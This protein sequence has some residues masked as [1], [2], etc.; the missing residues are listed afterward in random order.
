MLAAAGL[1]K[2]GPAKAGP[3]LSELLLK[4]LLFN[5][6]LLFVESLCAWV[7]RS[8]ESVKGALK[9]DFLALRMY[10]CDILEVIEH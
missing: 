7:E 4:E 9:C 2:K 3:F 8:C 1:I 5:E 10:C 6:S